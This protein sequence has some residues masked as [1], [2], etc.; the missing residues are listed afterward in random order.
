MKYVFLCN[1]M[2]ANCTLSRKTNKQKTNSANKN[3][4]RVFKPTQYPLFKKNQTYIL[5]GILC[6]IILI[7]FE[8]FIQSSANVSGFPSISFTCVTLN[9]LS[10]AHPHR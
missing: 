5:F 3:Y 7:Y 8:S 1:E 2:E 10:H 6:I 9:I 4:S